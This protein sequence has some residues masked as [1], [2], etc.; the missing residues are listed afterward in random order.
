M[1][2]LLNQYANFG[3]AD[4]KDR[5]IWISRDGMNFESSENS[6]GPR[7]TITISD[8]NPK[9]ITYDSIFNTMIIS[10]F[11]DAAATTISSYSFATVNR[12]GVATLPSIR[13]GTYTHPVFFP[14]GATTFTMPIDPPLSVAPSVANVIVT[15][16]CATGSTTNLTNFYVQSVSTTAITVFSNS[17]NLNNDISTFSW[18]LWESP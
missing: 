1:F 4:T 9:K 2:L 16:K 3:G 15:K 6:T 10:D 7:T 14:A 17:T 8:L 18:L 12:M 13:I 11:D 5:S